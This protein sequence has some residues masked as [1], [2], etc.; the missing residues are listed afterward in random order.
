MIRDRPRT[1]AA[2]E[3]TL[4]ST[5][6]RR[7]CYGTRATATESSTSRPTGTT[8][9]STA[10]RGSTSPLARSRGR[11]TASTPSTTRQR[12]T[13]IS[14]VRNALADSLILYLDVLDVLENDDAYVNLNPEGRAPARA[15]EDSIHPL[16]RRA[17]S[18][19][20]W[21]DCGS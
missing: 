17:R 11:R 21:R 20:S 12:T 14:C 18:R 9:A 19:S 2:A 3:V 1:S 5:A 13:L 6:P 7:M 15:G 10:P 16:E 8:S 4:R